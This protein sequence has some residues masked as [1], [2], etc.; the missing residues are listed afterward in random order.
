MITILK[1][2]AI[3]LVTHHETVWNDTSE[4][5]LSK[6]EVQLSYSAAKIS[7]WF[8]FWKDKTVIPEYIEN[9]NK[10]YKYK[11]TLVCA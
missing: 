7:D 3:T 9:M 5:K 4:K 2:T 1:V 6:F 10:Y 11:E 8:L